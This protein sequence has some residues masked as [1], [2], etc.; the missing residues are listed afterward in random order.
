MRLKRI[1]VMLVGLSGLLFLTP[2]T[3][4]TAETYYFSPVNQHGINL[5]AAYWNPILSYVSQKSGVKLT[6]KIGRTSADTTSYVLAQEVDFAFTNHLFSPERQQLGWKVFGRRNTPPLLGQLVVP[7][8]S[9]ITDLAQLA[10][11]DVAFPGPEALVS[12]KMPYAH[13]LSR[14][15]DIKVVFGGNMD[16]AL[17]QLF[18]GKVRAAGGNSQLIEGFAR[19]E[20]KAYRI[21]W[22]SE[23]V[24]D[25]ALMVS[26]KVPA[27]EAKAVADAFIGMA[28]DP[29][30]IEIIRKA[31]KL[32]EL[33]ED[34]V[35]LSSNG[36]EY[37]AYHDFFK[38][39]PAHLR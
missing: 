22:S 21:L 37:K 36:S 24:Y 39:A 5:T 8:D 1:F 34:A 10:G 7:A 30:G 27:K 16:A 3:A 35:F 32:I 19:R 6:L 14:G 29:A 11:Q 18:S 25:L 9:P 38:T 28:R 26:P 2:A 23:P 17:A 20:K 33:N 4:Q 31:S 12:Y 15:I 13:L